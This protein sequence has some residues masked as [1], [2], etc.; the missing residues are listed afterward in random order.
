M[1]IRDRHTL[2]E[3]MPIFWSQI[4]AGLGSFI[5]TQQIFLKTVE[6]SQR[7]F[8]AD[9]RGLERSESNEAEE[10]LFIPKP[11]QAE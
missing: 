7:E 6:I 9:K 8:E 4:L 1:C 10:E 2:K 5:L 11:S 3:G